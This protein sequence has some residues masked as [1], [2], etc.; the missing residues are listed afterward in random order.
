MT[1]ILYIILLSSILLLNNNLKAQGQYLPCSQSLLSFTTATVPTSVNQ[2]TTTMINVAIDNA[3]SAHLIAGNTY[4]LATAMTFFD[5]VMT[6]FDN[7]GF[8]QAFN[9]DGIIGTGSEINFSPL[10]TGNYSI[11]INEFGCGSGSGLPNLEITLVAE[12]HPIKTIP[13]VVHVVHY[14][15]AIGTERNISDAQI[16]DQI[17]TLNADFSRL[18]TDIANAPAVFRGVSANPNIQFCLAQQ[19]PNGVATNGITRHDASVFEGEKATW[20]Q[21]ECDTIIKPITIW[22]PEDYLNVWVVDIMKDDLSPGLLGYAQ[23]PSS[24]YEDA[25]LTFDPNTDG[26][27]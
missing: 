6:V 24:I 10:Y 20:T 16:H 5:P 18:N 1:R 3:A 23:F 4:K 13:V 17:A 27:V 19:D 7:M 22:N 9:D 25:G 26:V 21:S 14:G 12:A 2:T 15:E 11:Q 8:A